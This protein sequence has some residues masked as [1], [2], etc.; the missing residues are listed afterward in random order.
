MARVNAKNLEG[1]TPLHLALHGSHVDTLRCLLEGGASPFIRNTAGED[2]LS[3]ALTCTS[4]DI[5]QLVLNYSFMWATFQ[6]DVARLDALTKL[7]ADIGFR[8]SP[9]TQTHIKREI[10]AL[11]TGKPQQ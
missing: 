10:A 6:N 8:I 3:Q 2:V 9:R 7:G 5:R 4:A 11:A 1:N